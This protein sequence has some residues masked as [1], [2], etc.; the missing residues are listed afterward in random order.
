M[1]DHYYKNRVTRYDSDLLLRMCNALDCE[2]G[3]L[4]QLT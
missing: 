2:I 4:I 1:I 3:E